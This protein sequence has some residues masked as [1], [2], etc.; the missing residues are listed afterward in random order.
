M[1]FLDSIYHKILLPLRV[2]PAKGFSNEKLAFS[3][4][5]GLLVGCFPI[6]GAT[7]ILGVLLAGIFRQNLAIIQ[8]L[9]WVL[10]PV[11]LILIL[12][13]IRFG[14]ILF[15]AQDHKIQLHLILNAFDQGILHGIGFLGILSIYGIVAWMLLAIPAGLLCY[16]LIRFLLNS[17]KKK[18]QSSSDV[19]SRT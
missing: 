6:I 8:S 18:Q 7:T 9:N 10:A 2:L 16:Y 13:L 11:Q 3:L 15:Q 14:A 17:R 4:T 12:P 1:K 5:I 19:L